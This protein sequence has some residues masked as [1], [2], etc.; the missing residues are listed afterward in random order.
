MGTVRA[1]YHSHGCITALT[2]HCL[3]PQR[4]TLERW[5][6]VPGPSSV[7][8][9]PKRTPIAGLPAS[10]GGATFKAGTPPAT[11][12]SG[13]R[14]PCDTSLVPFQLSDASYYHQTDS[15]THADR[16]AVLDAQA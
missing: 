15:N 6:G 10:R 7:D 2:P 13:L 9:M 8:A 14:T 12:L 16:S 3:L 1:D 5:S 11:A 4:T